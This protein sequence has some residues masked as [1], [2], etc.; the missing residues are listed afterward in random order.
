MLSKAKFK[1]DMG[2]RSLLYVMEDGASAE[3]AIVGNEGILGIS[4]L[5][6]GDATPSRTVVQS[7]GHEHAWR[8]PRR[9]YRGCRQV[10]KNWI[11]SLLSRPDHRSGSSGA[12]GALL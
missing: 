8:S 6:G 5:I 10:A 11:D 7:K 12:G 9:R 1:S 3:I 2:I 4:L